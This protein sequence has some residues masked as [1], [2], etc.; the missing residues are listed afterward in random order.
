MTVVA[1]QETGDSYKLIKEAD[2]AGSSSNLQTAGTQR[3][4]CVQM[5]KRFQT[6]EAPQSQEEATKAKAL[7]RQPPKSLCDRPISSAALVW[8]GISAA[9]RYEHDDEELDAEIADH[10]RINESLRYEKI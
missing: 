3:I 5:A 4:S 2:L 6:V 8:A 1:C 10:R 9:N 7:L